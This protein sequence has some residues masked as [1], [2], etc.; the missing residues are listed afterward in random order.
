[1]SN[2]FVSGLEKRNW[3]AV[4]IATIYLSLGVLW[5]LFSD[6]V[7]ESISLDAYTHNWVNTLKGWAFVVFTTLLLYQLIRRYTDTLLMLSAEQKQA[8]DRMAR[9]ERLL[10]MFV[11]HSPAAIAMFDRNM[12]YI[13]VSHRYL[14]DYRIPNRNIIGRSLYE[15][16]PEISER[17]KEIHRR[18]LTGAVE[19]CEQ[20]LF[21]RADGSLNWVRWEMHP[22]YET[23]SEIGG[24]ILFSEDI[25]ERLQQAETLRKLQERF[26][27]AFRS[28]PVAQVIARGNGVYLETNEAF[29]RLTGYSSAQMRDRTFDE[30]AILETETHL[31][32]FD[33]I[34]EHGFVHDLQTTLR[35]SSGDLHEILLSVEPIELIDEAL[36][37]ATVIDIT[38]R[39]RAEKE[40]RASEQRYRSLFENMLNGFA[41]C[42]MLYQADSPYDFIL[43]G[44]NAAFESL[45][46][47]KDVVGRRVSEIL[48]ELYESNPEVFEICG[49]VASTGSPERFETFVPG[50]ETWLDVAVYSP[51]AEH[52][53]AV[54]DVINERKRGEQ[55][56]RESEERYRLISFVAS[57][58]MFSA[59][60]DADGNLTQH[61]VIGAFERITGYTVE[62]FQQMG[63]WGALVHPDDVALDQEDM[64]LLRNNQTASRELRLIRRDGNVIWVH[65]FGHPVWSE[66]ENRLVEIYGGVQD[67]TPRKQAELELR[68]SE[69]RFAKA[70][71]ANPAAVVIT[72]V[73]DGRIID[74]N[75]S[76]ERLFGYVK[77][78]IEGRTGVEL[79][80]FV[81][82][83]DRAN[84]VARVQKYGSVKD[85][86]MK[87]R[88]RLGE[89]REVLI[90]A[91]QIELQGEACILSLLFD[92]TARKRAEEQA[93]RADRLAQA[94]LDALPAEICVLDETGKIIAVNRAWREFALANPP[95]PP[96]FYLGENY[97][98]VCLRATG[99]NA[100]EA[101]P[102]A[103]GLRDVMRGRLLEFTLEYPCH[104]PW[105]KRW[106]AVSIA[107]FV[108]SSPVR[109]VVA[110][111]NITEIRQAENEIRYQAKLLANISDAII[112]TD[113]E[114]RVK[115][116]NQA[117][118]N[119]YGLTAAQVLGKRFS[120]LVS[121]QYQDTNA[122]NI[123]Q[124]FQ[125][126]G[127]WRGVTQQQ[128]ADGTKK[129][130]ASAVT[131][132]RDDTGEPTGTVSVNRDVTETMRSQREIQAIAA[133]S[134]AL[135]LA[136]TRAEML[137]VIFEQLQT[138]LE[139]TTTAFLEFDAV[140]GEIR[141]E[142]D[143]DTF[144]NALRAHGFEG[145]ELDVLA[146]RVPFI[147]N[148]T[149]RGQMIALNAALAEFGAVAGFPL[150]IEDKVIGALWLGRKDTLSES[151]KRIF[152]AIAD[153][154]ANAIYRT[155][156]HERTVEQL[157][158]LQLL[159][160]IES[161]I[162]SSYD[163]KST[164]NLFVTK[165]VT[166]LRVDAASV[167][168]LNPHM[169]YLEYTTGYGVTPP[170]PQDG[171]I[172][173]GEGL[174]GR[175]AMSREI[176]SVPNLAVHLMNEPRA[177]L[178]HQAEQFHTYCAVPL[179]AKG[180]VKGVLELL[181]C[182]TL[183]TDQEWFEFLKT[184]AQQAA[185]AIEDMQLYEGLQRSNLELGMA[186]DATIEGWSR[187]LDLRDKE[188]E[189]HTQRVTELTLRLAREFGLDDE[190]LVHIRRGALLH[191]IG[192]MG[193]PD[194]ILLK[195]DK[196]TETE[197]EIMQK[198]PQY[199]Y[200]MLQPIAYL[201]PALDIPYHHHERW[202]GTGYPF[203]LKGELIPL[204]ARI[205]AVVD[206]WDAVT[207]D[208]PYRPAWTRERALAYIQA[209]SGKHFDPEVVRRFIQLDAV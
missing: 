157:N 199:A 34:I 24:V 15:M 123:I 16:F 14:Q 137:L 8:Q 46:G 161:S 142:S 121:I 136:P 139:A 190:E 84:I 202:D 187:A 192:K 73:S 56:L 208:R 173:L 178:Y 162:A 79:N 86:E 168:L 89:L 116:W 70:F 156:L 105:E 115:S 63:G 108:D 177:T 54:F 144:A 28:S 134:S 125:D 148:E 129:Y 7:V 160:A 42:R 196:L 152:T 145:I 35:H 85:C 2:M 23:D 188:T 155:A 18:C 99:A 98:E 45:T 80:L 143:S 182:N 82:P 71:Y 20:D 138:L 179:L 92:I 103:S 95:T 124:E 158:R 149:P 176:V 133:V 53:V 51:K 27:K 5:I 200:D 94:T 97:L 206:V 47:L 130:I 172:W 25:T 4:Q 29:S 104:A 81:N 11:E 3:G 38:E 164:L 106:Y 48:P 166:H 183:P 17:W 19:R 61:W 67:I 146:R 21:L 174:A 193:V 122:A 147:S 41:D 169:F 201:K 163:L 6:R 197:W 22:W 74:V 32:I 135:R 191:D 204:A 150:V 83:A 107:R 26:S 33:D 113:L 87:V 1:M 57:D 52:F 180:Q 78:E 58:Y 96:D 93:Q 9:S 55:I 167:L 185:I 100:V 140:S 195:T 60:V 30:M 68:R 66:Q 127:T 110:H 13:V 118:E 181:S 151:D 59:H 186:Y 39:T 120:E 207:S 101:L 203:G 90:S 88:T 12:N 65:S 175:T 170:S 189:G 131:L 119:I 159:H 112:S 198:H 62:E 109:L 111:L 171:R 40:L 77:N 114:Y 128:L 205:F 75:E 126:K 44:V 91:E 154:A 117:A 69:E 49:R 72:R 209:E 37:L 153:I 36:I 141:V 10:R 50:L 165:M 64:A 76:Y 43:L 132:L 194:H 184:V 31:K 102:F